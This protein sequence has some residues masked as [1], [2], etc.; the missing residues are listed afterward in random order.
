MTAAAKTRTRRALRRTTASAAPTPA[1]R[2]LYRSLQALEDA[3]ALR[4]ARIAA[5]CAACTDKARCDDHG[6]DVNLIAGYRQDAQLV[7]A[8]L[9]E[10]PRT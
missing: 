6:Q 3:I 5:P 8:A 7:I 9:A 1:T 10:P 2:R 4:R